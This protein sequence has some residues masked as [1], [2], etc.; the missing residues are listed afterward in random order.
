MSTS[1]D[2]EFMPAN[3]YNYIRTF[4]PREKVEAELIQLVDRNV[5]MFFIFTSGVEAYMNNIN[6]FQSMYPKLN[7]K[8]NIQVE[9]YRASDHTFSLL[10]H[11]KWVQD[12]IRNWLQRY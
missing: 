12:K 11:R 2:P 4:P 8:N 10:V 9:F 7:F 1:F 3:M 5:D 6:Q